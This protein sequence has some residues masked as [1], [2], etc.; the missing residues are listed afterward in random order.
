MATLALTLML[1]GGCVTSG[2]DSASQL[3]PVPADIQTCFRAS[4]TTVP[5][6]AL[7]AY[8]VESLWK[9]DRV[10]FIVMKKCGNR[11]LSWYESLR[12]N[13]K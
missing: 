3:P 5:D 9:S 6:R 8:D 4:S 13:W 11:F 2:S 1:L 7:T 10:K 12:A